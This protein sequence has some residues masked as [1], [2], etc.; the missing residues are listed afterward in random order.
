MLGK[1]I[2]H[3]SL[4]DIHQVSDYRLGLSTIQRG[5]RVRSILDPGSAAQ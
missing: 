5:W 2:L 1:F 4:K 3:T